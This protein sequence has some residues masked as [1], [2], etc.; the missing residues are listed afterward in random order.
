MDKKAG[1][2]LLGTQLIEGIAIDKEIFHSGM[3]KR[4]DDA[5][6]ALINSPLENEK[7]EFTAK[8]S[9]RAKTRGSIRSIS[10]S[11]C[12]HATRKGI[13]GQVS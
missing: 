6:I 8:I 12:G 5:N 11:S 10:S 13:S 4:I 1:E 2:S 7:T 3:P 9:A